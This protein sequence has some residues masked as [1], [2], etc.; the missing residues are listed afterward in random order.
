MMADPEEKVSGKLTENG[1]CNL[2]KALL[3]NATQW[4]TIVYYCFATCVN[5]R[6]YR[7]IDKELAK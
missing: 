5:Y 2:F 3:S 6:I 1:V 7:N 4:L